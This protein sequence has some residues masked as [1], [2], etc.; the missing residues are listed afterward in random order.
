MP[1][2]VTARIDPRDLLIEPGQNWQS[3][4]R[5]VI[6]LA[7]DNRIGL[8]W[9]I[10]FAASAGLFGIMLIC[11]AWQLYEGVGVW[12]NNN[13]VEWALDIV[14]YDWWIGIAS[15]ALV[16]SA[17]LLLT[18]AQWR[19]ALNR[20]TETM[21][22]VAAAAAGLYPIVH[23]GRPWFFYW[24]LPYPNTFQLW[25]QVRSPL[26]WDAIDIVSYLGITLSFWYVG[27]IPDLASMRDRA[28]ERIGRG[29]GMP[30]RLL[31]AQL[32]GLAAAG[33]RGS[34]MHWARWTQVY[35]TIAIFGVLLV[36]SLQTG[37]SVMFAGVAEPG[38]HDTLLPVTFL[39]GSILSGVGGVAVLAVVLRKVFRL[40]PLITERHL[41]LIAILLLGLAILSLY[42]EAASFGLTSLTGSDYD[43]ATLARRLTGINAWSTWTL[44]T[45]ALIPPHLFWIPAL[46]R[47]GFLLFLV[48]LLA[49]IGI[50][51][52]HFMVIVITLQHD[53]L[54]SSAHPYAPTI[55]GL[56][57]FFGSVGLFAMLILLFLRYLP[58]ISVVEVR[59]LL[60]PEVAGGG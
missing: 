35:R 25:P 58:A 11:L 49:V 32:Y 23:L 41:D 21:G 48:G 19:G 60:Q 13:P 46:R 59:R 20:I 15:G 31:R 45:C 3:V 40:G 8:R 14:S 39:A 16:V 55:W 6:G 44:I 33:W 57:T 54:P 53:Y 42:C 26:F 43:K 7:L 12:G 1:D 27:L 52:D 30:I 56:G 50:Y 5:E 10:A 38:W 47:S 4:E 2:T 28:V 51:G 37:A 34:A 36:L 17:V 9:W 18:D 24:N 22:L 29:P